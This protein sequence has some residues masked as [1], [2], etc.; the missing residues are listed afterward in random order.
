MI[1][2]LLTRRELEVLNSYPLKT[3]LEV[4]VKEF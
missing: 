4:K 3:L 2:P 1:Q